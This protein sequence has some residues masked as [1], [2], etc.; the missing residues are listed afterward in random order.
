MK[1]LA[2]DVEEEINTQNDLIDRITDQTDQAHFK[3]E[4]QNK[5]MSKLLKK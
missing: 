3:I 4:Q 5:Q 2:L 1:N